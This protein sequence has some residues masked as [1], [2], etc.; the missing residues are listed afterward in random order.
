VSA[1]LASIGAVRPGR[2]QRNTVLIEAGR[3]SVFWRSQEER[4]RLLRR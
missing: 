4:D 2:C 1:I 3:V